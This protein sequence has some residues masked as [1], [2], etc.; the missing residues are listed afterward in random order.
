MKKEKRDDGNKKNANK[1]KQT[2]NIYIYKYIKRW[3][4]NGNYEWET[5][6]IK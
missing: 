4:Q 1:Y 2:K 5:E 3:K 6:K